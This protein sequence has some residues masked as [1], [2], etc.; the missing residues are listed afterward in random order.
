VEVLNL[1]G[2]EDRWKSIGLELN[3][4]DSTNDGFHS[5]RWSLRFRCVCPRYD[6]SSSGSNSKA[7][8]RKE[9]T[10]SGKYHTPRLKLTGLR[11]RCARRANGCVLFWGGEGTATRDKDD[12]VL[13]NRLEFFALLAALREIRVTPRAVSIMVNDGDDEDDDGCKG[14]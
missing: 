9:K 5:P 6:P 8:K 14:F 12:A 3:I 10:V 1:E 4:D 11:C 2:I 7:R 13:M